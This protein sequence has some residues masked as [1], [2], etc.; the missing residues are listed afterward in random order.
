VIF[1]AIGAKYTL[2][3][4]VR[5]LFVRGTKRDS[6]QLSDA[7]RERYGQ[8]HVALYHKGR[9]AL[10][11][12]VKRATSYKDRGAV[13]ISGLTCYSVVQA[14]EAAGMRPVFV[15]IDEE[16]LHFGAKE[17][18]AALA[19]NPDV[20]AV[21][22][23]NMLGIPADIVA[24]QKVVKKAGITLIED[25]AHSAGATYADGR[26]VGTIGDIT[27]LSFGRDKA[28]DTV[29]GGAL[30]LRHQ[31]GKP[32]L[33][34]TSLNDVKRMD[35]FRDRLYPL[36]AWTTRALYSVKIGKYVMAVAIK[37]KLVVRSAD[38][39]ADDAETL[40]HWQAKSAQDQVR[41]LSEA[42]AARRDKAQQYISQL[43]EFVPQNAK[44]QGAALIRVPLLVSNRDE[45]VAH[46]R[47]NGV[48]AND[49][50]YDVPVSPVRFY[51]KVGYPET[52]CPVAVRT[53]ARLVNLPTHERI[54][55]KDIAYISKLVREV[56]KS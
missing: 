5:H 21:I 13:A 23:Q 40:P 55:S 38:G 4:V 53:A 29:N 39:G 8:D 3:A 25:L 51:D 27:M 50:W 28:I 34:N 12:A 20:K 36:I 56:A 22:V 1:Q 31:F 24:I 15:D 6:K 37:L 44:E 2:G 42:A 7:L 14:V 45:I 41:R 47:A 54:N 46:L 33:E 10:A 49:I 48:Q 11:E 26:E 52:E 43:K 18:K 19:K 32:P 35:Q 16:T 9:M 30:L 17:L